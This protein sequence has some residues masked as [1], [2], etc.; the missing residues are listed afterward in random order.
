[1]ALLCSSLI[2]IKEFFLRIIYLLNYHDSKMLNRYKNIMN[3][4]LP[5]A[6]IVLENNEELTMQ[7]LF[8]NKALEQL[9]DLYEQPENE[10]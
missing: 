7:S 1:M 8:H 5:N 9:F 6:L 2:Y 3:M 10:Y 4:D